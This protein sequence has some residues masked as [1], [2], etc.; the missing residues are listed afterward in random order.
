MS[1]Q[2]ESD[3]ESAERAFVDAVAD[4]VCVD[5]LETLPESALRRL[6]AHEALRNKAL[7]LF[8]DSVFY[9][10]ARRLVEMMDSEDEKI[11]VSA[12]G[13]LLDL[14]RDVYKAQS[15]RKQ[16]KV[17]LDKLFEDGFDF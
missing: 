9:K 10:A 8:A 11:V 13:K 14:R 4:G 6:E 7:E 17:P 2:D 1:N 5:S 15:L 12:A 3:L 16:A